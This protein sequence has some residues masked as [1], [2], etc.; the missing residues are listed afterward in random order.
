MTWSTRSLASSLFVALALFTGTVGR[1]QPA[2]NIALPEERSIFLDRAQDLER[3]QLWQ[4][5]ADLYQR[6][7]RLYPEDSE[8]R[9]RWYTAEQFYSL[10]R[11]YHDS[12]FQQDLLTLS[13]TESLGLYREVLAKIQT[14]YVREV[15]V[16]D[17]VL[18]GYRTLAVALD[19]PVFISTN[20]PKTS[21]EVL[22]QLRT[23]VA[24]AATRLGQINSNLEASAELR[25]VIRLCTV[26]GCQHT[27]A[28]PLEFITGACE[29]LDPYT[30]HL[31][32]NRLDEL[33][34][35][36]D[37]NFVG[38]GVEVRGEDKGLRIVEVL[39]AS[40]AQEASLIDAELILAVDG[41]RLAGMNAEEAA[42][43]LQGPDGTKVVIEVANREGQPRTVTIT[44]REVIVHSVREARI[45]ENTAGVAYVRI[46]SFQKNTEDELRVV[47][48]DLEKK[49][50][51]S[52]VVD[53]RGNPGGLLDVSLDVANQFIGDGILVST[54]GR[55]WGQ[56]WAHRARPK[57]TRKDPIVVLVDSESASASEIFA[58]AIQDHHRGVIVGT[59]TYGK[60][61]VQ[62]IFPLT[63][64]RTG[65]RLT[66]AHFFSPTDKRLQGVGVEPDVVVTRGVSQLG[67]EP[68]VE[69]RPTPENDRQLRMALEHI[70]S[71]S[72]AAQAR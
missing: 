22:A 21:P 23:R 55:A 67:E 25:N 32:P 63:T 57:A 18:A 37:G 26:H 35:M 46:E 65:L 50:M 17:L 8:L 72:L 70:A 9:Q 12:S 49:G 40:P 36:I 24:Q 48:D 71:D 52:L 51:R 31:S 5:A 11:R 53:L 64:V 20:F 54:R 10:S 4:Q 2:T 33:Y 44:R 61:S 38:L 1:A 28:A 41:I 27:A 59:R 62:S 58:S 39:P 29:S 69:R 7:L 3:R 42:N 15:P 66:T 68:P 14:H 56:N 13:E 6:A 34:S 60:G 16:R 43:R 47:L 30:T 45:I 19:R